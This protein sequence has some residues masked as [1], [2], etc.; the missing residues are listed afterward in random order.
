MFHPPQRSSRFT[1]FVLLAFL[2][3]LLIVCSPNDS[4]TAERRR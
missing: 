2:G 4:T 1:L 3:A